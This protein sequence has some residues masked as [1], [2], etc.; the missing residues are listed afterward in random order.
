MRISWQ[1][2]L[3]SCRCTCAHMVNGRVVA[4]IHNWWTMVTTVSLYWIKFTISSFDPLKYRPNSRK[5]VRAEHWTPTECEQEP[6]HC[7]VVSRYQLWPAATTPRRGWSCYMSAARPGQL[8]SAAQLSLSWVVTAK[9]INSYNS[10]HS[11]AAP[12]MQWQVLLLAMFVNIS[13]Q[14][15]QYSTHYD[16]WRH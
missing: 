10:C 9:L 11:S 2:K 8:Q 4:A 13:L 14:V 16:N 5:I 7:N 12:I 3:T 6:W 1:I 15:S